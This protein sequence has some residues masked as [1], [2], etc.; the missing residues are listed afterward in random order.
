MVP[1]EMGEGWRQ[2]NDVGERKEVGTERGDKLN[3][4]SE[5]KRKGKSNAGIAEKRTG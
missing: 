2:G 4:K 5:K 1:G 3:E